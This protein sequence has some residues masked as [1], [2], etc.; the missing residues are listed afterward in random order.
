T[1]KGSARMAGAMRLGQLAHLMEAR[2]E[3]DKF[4][5]DP[6]LFDALYEDLDQIAF[7]LDG[8]RRGEVDVEW[9]W[10]AARQ[11]QDAE[12]ERT[13]EPAIAPPA[14]PVA[15]RPAVV[16]LTPH[17][18]MPTVASRPRTEAVPEMEAG[19]RAQLRVR[20]DT[21]DRLVNE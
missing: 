13:P 8:L 10:V 15:E 2:L 9:P 11:A 12:P 4:A 6:Q 14:P 21:I 7:V 20:A 16:P 1:F 18:P 5:A 17:T 3:E 19:P